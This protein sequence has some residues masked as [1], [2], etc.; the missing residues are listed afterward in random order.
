MRIPNLASRIAFPLT[1]PSIVAAQAPE[2]QR[3][4]LQSTGDHAN[5]RSPGS[6]PLPTLTEPHYYQPCPANVVMPNGR[7]ECLG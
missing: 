2:G 6:Q 3:G 4:A 1:V 7:H 5:R